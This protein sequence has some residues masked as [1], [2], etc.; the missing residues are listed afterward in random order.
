MGWL[1]S[2]TLEDEARQELSLPQVV[3]EYEDVPDEL[4]GLPPY[5]DVDFTLHYHP[6]SCH[7]RVMRNQQ[8]LYS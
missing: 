6:D 7:G 1:T 5:R 3:C 8:N 2:L 4:P